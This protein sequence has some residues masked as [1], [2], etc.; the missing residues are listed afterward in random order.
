V[1]PEDATDKTVVWTSSSDA[2]TVVDGTVTAIA[3]G[4]AT[5]TA[6]AGSF[7]DTIEITVRGS[8]VITAV[9]TEGL[10]METAFP[11]SD[12]NNTAGRWS[13]AMTSY[14][15]EPTF[16]PELS[17][18]VEGETEYKNVSVTWV[19]T[20]T[21]DGTATGTTYT[22]V[23]QAVGYVFEDAPEITV[24][25]VD[26]GW[27]EK[28]SGDY[29]MQSLAVPATTE[30]N[31]GEPIAIVI[32]NDVVY[33]ATG[34]NML[35]P[36]YVFTSKKYALFYGG[37][38]GAPNGVAGKTTAKSS[39]GTTNVTLMGTQKVSQVYGGGYSASH[40]GDT[41]V[42]FIDATIT[43]NVFGGGRAAGVTGNTNI[44]ISG[45]SKVGSNIYGGSYASGTVTGNS[46]IDISG[47]VTVKNVYGGGYN[48]SV[49]G[50]ATVKI[51]DL[52][53]GWSI[54]AIS[55]GEANAM[56]I[57][58]DTKETA[59][60]IFP[61]VT[62]WT[63]V[64]A[65][66]NGQ[67]TTVVADV[68]IAKTEYTVPNGTE[69]ADVGLP[70]TFDGVSGFTWEGAYNPTEAGTYTL[71]LKAPEDVYLLVDVAVTVT[72]EKKVSFYINSITTETARAQ[73]AY[74]T[75]L[76][77]VKA[78]LPA[79][80]VANDG[81]LTVNGIEW[82]AE[83][84]SSKIPGEYTFK[85]ILT[86]VEYRYADG[87]EP[88]KA[89]VTVKVPEGEGVVVT[90]I[91]LPV[92]Y[93]VF[94]TST[95]TVTIR[96][97]DDG[98]VTHNETRPIKFYDALEAVAYENGVRKEIQIT[99]I[100]WEGTLT[101]TDANG[102]YRTYSI[103]S[104]N[105]IVPIAPEII[106]ATTITAYKTKVVYSAYSGAFRGEGNV[107]VPITV[108]QSEY[109]A[110][111]G[112]YK[113]YNGMAI[114]DATGLNNVYENIQI[115]NGGTYYGSNKNDVTGNASVTVES[116]VVAE[117]IYGGGNTGSL[118]GNSVVT[119]KSGSLISK[120][121]Y[122]GSRQAEFI[123]DSTINVESGATVSGKI[124]ACGTGKFDG[125]V[126][127]NVENGASIGG[128]TLGEVTANYPDSL[129]INV[130][131]GFDLSL[132][133][134]IGLNRVKVYVD[135]VLYQKVTKVEM[136]EKTVVNVALGTTE[137]DVGLPSA[138]AATV[139]GRQGTVNVTWLCETYDAN[140]AGKYTFKP[141]VSDAYDVSESNIEE[142]SVIVRVLT[143]NAGQSTITGFAPTQAVLVTLGTS[144]KDVVLP[145]TVTA[146]VNGQSVPVEVD[147]WTCNG[148][149]DGSV[150]GA[151][152][153]YTST[154]SGEYALA[155]SAP[156]VVVKI[157]KGKI[158]QI[159]LPV[160]E[161]TFP[162]G[163]VENPVFY[164]TL[165][166]KLDNGTVTDISG[167]KWTVKDY[168]KNALGTYTATIS[169]AP[170]NCEFAASLTLPAIKVTVT[171][172][173][174]DVFTLDDHIYL[175]GIPSVIDGND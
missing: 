111:S 61:L 3:E 121:V 59:I 167:F 33:D 158:A 21:Y 165:K 169:S 147:R 160:T 72:V 140:T 29:S 155:V 170:E 91:K 152:Y 97:V 77:D 43:G 81:A 78:L 100:E 144:E 135:G 6:T 24:T 42:R 49:N 171:S 87:A 123:G 26:A 60:K 168:D 138:L 98:T 89:V 149:Y 114:M 17:V 130:T 13:S 173:K 51:H 159:Y 90:E 30:N 54:G 8:E 63:N 34:C 122:A 52:E 41:Y 94:T 35:V 19:C 50:T 129:T 56:V 102:E 5:I 9:D 70:T 18:L 92:N 164:D 119:L 1:E 79:Q 109:E 74:G 83:E 174:Y 27:T 124:Y 116:G 65:R 7:S 85:A 14:V 105:S 163:T 71:T 103:K 128:I 172:K 10:V 145:S 4:T 166:V 107:V 146:T 57:D 120:N 28:I 66:I 141:V 12:K 58:V 55:K 125:D 148:V 2:V 73:V 64:T 45:N 113:G 127:I 88:F 69:L 133:D 150:Y 40:T 22:F 112:G 32:K 99:D 134:C 136:P 117:G 154:V 139:N 153:T 84:Y 68:D 118:T 93:T 80:F 115:S 101:R 143:A 48:A 15:E 25:I 46:N 31:A 53:E 11:Y 75:S 76:D 151:E 23:P 156:T 132:I 161:T 106:D 175:N 96:D 67:E 82:T 137:N 110:Y 37:I 108:V 126:V 95:G 47:K 62:D 104:Y 38:Q 157:T 44:I 162:R 36:D 39:N 20:T 142:I 16:Y 86:D 131:S